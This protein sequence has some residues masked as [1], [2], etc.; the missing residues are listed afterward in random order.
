MSDPDDWR[1]WLDKAASDLLNIDNNLRADCIPWD[2]VCFH[3]QQ[4]AEKLL[5]GLLVARG[6]FVPRTH[7]L[8][9]LLG[10]CAAAGYSI[11]AMRDDCQRLQ[12]YSVLTRYPGAPFEPDEQ[13]GRLAAEVSH[14]IQAIVLAVLQKH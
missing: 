12:P 2:T 11:D 9:A 13:E 5:K 3:A 7:D 1:I 4:A 6:E 10:R 8:A 14:R